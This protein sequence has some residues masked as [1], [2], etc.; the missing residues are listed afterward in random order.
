[1]REL[2]YYPGCS[3]H[4][5]SVEYDESIREVISALDIDLKELE[6]WNCCG[7]SSGHSI[8]G[9]LGHELS[10]RNLTLAAKSGRDV[11]VPCAACFNRLRSAQVA[12][13]EEKHAPSPE[14]AVKLR[15]LADV[16]SE[17]ALLARIA[18]RVRK[19]LD[20]ISAVTYYGCLVVRPPV[21]TGAANYE[22]PRDID[23]VLEAMGVK[24]KTWS[25]KTQCCGGGLTL[26]RPDAVT[27]LSKKILDR[28]RE[29]GAECVVAICPMCLMNLEICQFEA[30]RSGEDK[31]KPPIPIVYLTEI[32]GVALG[33][34]RAPQ[35]LG[36]HLVDPRPLFRAKGLI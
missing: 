13:L 10:T 20:Q 24:M 3:L 32:V 21:V 31:G 26:S 11:V 19:P 34:P 23:V 9:K 27:R 14:T 15:S 4:G 12:V 1:M 28:V 5:T 36:K 35:W 29:I 18:Q 17:S 16:L 33:L 7:A 22:D 30:M 25:Y 8:G 2:S 6:D